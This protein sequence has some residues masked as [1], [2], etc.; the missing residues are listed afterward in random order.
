M[1]KLKNEFPERIIRVNGCHECDKK[2]SS[3]QFLKSGGITTLY[4]CPFPNI[5]TDDHVTDFVINKTLPDNCPLEKV[6][7]IIVEVKEE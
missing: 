5:V 3:Q 6:E 7:Q 2:G 1:T 4:W